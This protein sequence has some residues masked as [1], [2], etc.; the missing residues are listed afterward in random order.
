MDIDLENSTFVS[1]NLLKT[2]ADMHAEENVVCFPVDTVE[3]VARF[4]TVD[5]NIILCLHAASVP[6]RWM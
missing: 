2:S 1:P 5:L 6:N 3:S 4:C